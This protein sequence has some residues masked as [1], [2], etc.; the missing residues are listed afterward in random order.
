[1][2]AMILVVGLFNEKDVSINSKTLILNNS[3]EKVYEIL[4]APEKFPEWNSL[5]KDN[6]QVESKIESG[7]IY[8][9]L[10]ESEIWSHLVIQEKLKN[11]KLVYTVFMDNEQQNSM[12]WEMIPA[13][14]DTEL[15]CTF[16]QEI[17]WTVR[18][19]KSVMEKQILQSV[20]NTVLDLKKYIESNA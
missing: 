5:L 16:K 2:L 12:E 9:K 20:D 4:L 3:P 17:H 6:N 19:L 13:G 10:K 7:N 1:M 18:F 11:K 15:H 14:N 8:W